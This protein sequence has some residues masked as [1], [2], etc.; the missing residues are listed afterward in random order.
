MP[1]TA[2]SETIMES[3]EDGT[4]PESTDTNIRYAAYAARL[5]TIISSAHRYIAYTSDIGESFRPITRPEL[6]RAAY[7][8]SWAYLIGDVAYEGY[9][10]RLAQQETLS[11]TS[12][13]MVA[14]VTGQKE[15]FA[16][17]LE[18]EREYP[19]D[20]RIAVVKRAVFQSVASMALP[21]F[22]IHS[23]VK[24]ST[25]LFKD[26]PNPRLRLWGPVGLGL[27]VVPMLPYF[28]DE[29][30]EKVVDW[31]TDELM[32]AYAARRALT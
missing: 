14:D 6:V 13:R 23:T 4:A 19:L 1:K 31:G 21:A 29:P 28:F 9:R 20:W 26:S 11:S 18:A 24:Y 8:I 25:K 27:A 3:I 22:T 2:T 30:V 7:G 15:S 5:R 10:A 17:D 16:S 12:A 32:H